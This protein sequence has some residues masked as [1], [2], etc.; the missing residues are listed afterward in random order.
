MA[1]K[2]IVIGID[3]GG[4]KIST[5]L[6][7]S[8]GKII[9]Q[10]YRKTMA[11]EGQQAV[12]ERILN[13]ARQ[14]MSQAKVTRSQ[15]AAVGICAPGP[16]DIEAGVVVAP[17]N[18]P[19]WERVPLKQL[20][21]DN[22]GIT[23][24]LENDANA[25]ALSEHRFGAGRGV[26]HMIYITVS[27]GIGGGLILDGK[28]YHGA[29][30]MAGEVG[31]ITIEPGGPLCGCGN[32]GCLEALASGTA[33]ARV[34]R[35]R[36]AQ[37]VPTLMTDMTDGD[38]ERITARLVAEAASRGDSEAQEILSEAMDYLG[39]GMAN[40]VNLFNPQLIV[41]GGGLMNIG[42]KLFRPVRRAIDQ[43]TFTPATQAVRVVP[44][45]LGDNAG[46]LGAAAVALSQLNS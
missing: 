22:L 30:G 5:A 11:A 6:V 20:I 23:T 17:P 38:P 21:E 44:A 36:V 41:I 13:S 14:V 28:L 40:L 12:I 19:G 29:S 35:E 4:T 37:N 39:I 45:A 24:F 16:L 15:V 26:E 9:A 43:H 8:D 46:V 1:S 25:A 34:A 7:E 10:D 27:T 32:R 18:L 42:E 33:I 2:H 3:L 31:H